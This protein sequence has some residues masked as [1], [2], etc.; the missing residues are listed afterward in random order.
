MAHSSN[1]HSASAAGQH[2]NSSTPVSVKAE[3]TGQ[4]ITATALVVKYKLQDTF[5]FGGIHTCNILVH[6]KA[7]Q[8]SHK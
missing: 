1:T 2:N 3:A 5:F 8:L 7:C 6:Q 4:V